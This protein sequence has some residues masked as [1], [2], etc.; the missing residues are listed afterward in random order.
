MAQHN[1]VEWENWPWEVVEPEID[2][3]KSTAQGLIG[4]AETDLRSILG[5][6]D[7][8][9][10]G[11]EGW[12]AAGNLLYRTDYSLRYFSLLPHT[13]VH[14]EITDHL[15]TSIGYRGKWKRCPTDRIHLVG[16]A[17]APT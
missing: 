15:V 8:E 9:F 1:S 2:D 13:C 10:P 16:A 12:D 17:F 3:F 7:Q 5:V 4:M 14:V 6:P 11:S